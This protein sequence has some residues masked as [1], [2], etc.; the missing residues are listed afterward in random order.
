[1]GMSVRCP[2]GIALQL[3]NS[4]THQTPEGAILR[5]E[6]GHLCPTAAQLEGQPSPPNAPV[7]FTRLVRSCIIDGLAICKND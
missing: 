3:T 2:A 5:I 1:M 6:S 7:Q 4:Q